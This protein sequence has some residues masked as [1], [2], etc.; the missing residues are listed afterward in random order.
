M[1][2]KL[3]RLMSKK[4]EARWCLFN[5]RSAFIEV[6]TPTGRL[7]ATCYRMRI[8]TPYSSSR[9]IKPDRDKDARGSGEL[10]RRRRTRYLEWSWYIIDG[11]D[12]PDKRPNVPVLIAR[13]HV[14]DAIALRKVRAGPRRAV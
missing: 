5:Y 14:M 9:A 7:I 2:K 10:R 6:A 13:R 8:M 3:E 1:F 11:E 4:H 12:N